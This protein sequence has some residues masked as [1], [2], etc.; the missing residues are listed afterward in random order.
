MIK[1]FTDSDFELNLTPEEGSKF[2]L[3]RAYLAG[4]T[5]NFIG[6]GINFS[7]FNRM[8]GAVELWH[9]QTP[10]EN[11]IDI[12]QR[13]T[14]VVHI[15]NISTPIA[16]GLKFKVERKGGKPFRVVIEYNLY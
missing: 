12:Y 1:E 15:N 11:Y 14:N 4:D 9:N 5:R 8:F 7:I 3:K 16:E 10:F 13:Q 2:V 6:S